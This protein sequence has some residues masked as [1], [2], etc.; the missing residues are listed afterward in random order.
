MTLEGGTGDGAVPTLAE[1]LPLLIDP[2]RRR[3]YR[4]IDRVVLQGFW[5]AWDAM[6]EGQRQQAL[7]PLSNKLR[8]QLL[9]P[10]VRDALVQPEAPDL[11][12]FI[13]DRRIVFCS[14]PSGTEDG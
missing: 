10:A 13:A 11:R 7:A 5:K 8:A 12:A 3:R 2:R 4:V 1:V 14:L 9:R 6:S